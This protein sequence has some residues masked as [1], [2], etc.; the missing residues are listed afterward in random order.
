MD[1]GSN[2]RMNGKR[3]AL[4]RWMAASVFAAAVTAGGAGCGNREL[5]AGDTMVYTLPGGAE[6]EMVWCPPGTF[7]MGS[8][9]GERTSL[10]WGLSQIVDY[11]LTYGEYNNEE[12][13]H[14]VTLTK[15][16]W[17]AKYEVTQEQW[18]SVMGAIPAKYQGDG[19]PV[20]NVSWEDCQAFC[21]KAGLQLPTEAQWEYACR[22]GN[23]GAIGGT[24][25]LE[26]MG[27]V[28]KGSFEPHPVGKKAPNTWGL[29]DMYG[30]VEEW[31]A[32]W[33]GQYPDEEVADPTGPSYGE[34][35]IM[36]GG[37]IDRW[38][39]WECRSA[40][41]NMKSPQTASE[42][43]GFRPVFTGEAKSKVKH[44][45]AREIKTDHVPRK[46]KAIAD[47][48]GKGA[49]MKLLGMFGVPF[50]M[51]MSAS[52]AC[53][54]NIV[55]GDTLERVYEFTPSKPLDGFGNYY[56][57]ATLTTRKVTGIRADYGNGEGWAGEDDPETVFKN[58]IGSLEQR[59]GQAVVY[60]GPDQGVFSFANS[61]VVGVAFQMT[62]FDFPKICI[63]A[64][65]PE[66]KELASREVGDMEAEQF[67]ADIRVLAMTPAKRGAKPVPRVDSVFG[68]VF[69]E[70][71]RWGS[72]P[73]EN[74]EYAWAYEFKPDGS[75]MGCSDFVVFATAQSKRVFG[76]RAVFEGGSDEKAQ[77]RYGQLRRL[78][79][80][81]TGYKFQAVEAERNDLAC[82]MNI[83][84]QTVVML[85][86]TWW[87]GKVMLDFMNVD[88][89]KEHEEES[90]AKK[91]N[92]ALAESFQ[93]IRELSERSRNRR[94]NFG[95]D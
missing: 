5:Q 67:G 22:A 79:E 71:C 3:N 68:I 13:Q 70:P 8:P 29:H 60:M 1:I 9:S 27:W 32:D 37:G 31:C 20:G 17:I 35:R 44:G 2:G 90:R 23:T 15:G 69:G 6:M 34:Y 10:E 87:Q 41:R 86:K 43:C 95:E 83:G 30:N 81:E 26:E 25:K 75:F 21:R 45:A 91:T 77:W 59:F 33:Y 72:N 62:G 49:E 78:I 73:Q 12:N 48:K 85:H 36:R 84:D 94:N 42:S 66:L 56:L 80:R 28:W 46:L 39:E 93:R 58:A 51:T 16:F 65:S 54:T 92:D 61:N 52:E 19:L 40:F 14:T 55:N 18:K 50:G 74:N 76:V 63:N 24:G 88:L 47:T 57:F 82:R 89:V 38:G 7:R 11:H 64:I 4:A 53:T